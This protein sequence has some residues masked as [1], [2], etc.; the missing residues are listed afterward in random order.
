MRKPYFPKQD[1]H[2][3]PL[4]AVCARRVRFE[5]VDPLSIVWHGRYPS[6]FEDA[7]MVLGDKYGIGY[8]TFYEH[9]VV[10]PIKMMHLDYHQPLRFG[11]EFTVEGIQHFSES[12]RI[13]TEYVVRNSA[14]EVATTGYT[15]QM[16]LDLKMNVLIA[17]PPFFEAFCDRWKR[18]ESCAC[19]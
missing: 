11:E 5:E 16:L 17:L 9:G 14:G 13:N 12:A 4:R 15:V 1:G 6:F 7:R 18:E 2:P 10:T 19:T 8:M 3:E